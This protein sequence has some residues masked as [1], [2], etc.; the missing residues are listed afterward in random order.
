MGVVWRAHDEL[1]DRAVAVKEVRHQPM[2]EKDR[3]AFN[4][5]TIREARAA[6]RLSHPNVVVI[7]DVIEEDGRPW[8]VMQLIEARSLGDVLRDHGPLIPER[9]AAIGLQVLEAL[10]TAHT[11]G[12]LHRDVKPEN[13]LV[14]ADGRVVL[15]DFGI[16]TMPEE[17]GLTM[18]G[19]VIG[20][21][22]YMPPE[23]LHG[24]PATPESDLWSLGATLY[25]AV[26]GKSPFERGSAAATMAA[27]L[28]EEPE[29]SPRAGPLAEVIEGLLRKDPTQR[30]DISETMDLLTAIAAGY[31]EPQRPRGTASVVAARPRGRHAIAAPTAVESTP[32]PPKTRVATLTADASPAPPD[33]RPEPPAEPGPSSEPEPDG[34]RRPMARRPV[35]NGNREQSRRV[36]VGGRNVTIFWMTRR[37]RWS[38]EHSY[39]APFLNTFQLT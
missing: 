31:D 12:V 37:D 17:P 32:T 9:A 3:A 27:V 34:G 39:L 13:V 4:R 36:P 33:I 29:P 30:I 10:C 1:L 15:T 23:R 20:T 21:P 7:H 6:G 19:S 22:A 14:R 35:R 8:I 5:R 16:A 2:S 38:R 26:E 28:S 11:A 25:A 24:A 18:T